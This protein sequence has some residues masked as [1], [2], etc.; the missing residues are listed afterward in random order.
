MSSFSSSRKETES[1]FLLN[2]IKRYYIENEHHEISIEK[3]QIFSEKFYQIWMKPQIISNIINQNNEGYN[4]INY[5][6][7]II[8]NNKI[9]D[10]F[11]IL[12]I[13]TLSKNENFYHLLLNN[14]QR[15]K[16][17]FNSSIQKPVYLMRLVLKCF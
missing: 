7:Q 4:I 1:S 12:I 13:N 15:F 2:S 5:L 10:S 8:L 16:Q 14:H 9:N 6:E 11:F 17:L 3:I